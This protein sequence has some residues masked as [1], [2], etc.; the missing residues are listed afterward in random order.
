VTTAS[1]IYDGTVGH[2]RVDPVEHA[3][4]YRQAML[5]LDL[6][7]APAL[8]ERA[9]LWSMRRRAPG[10]FRRSDY[11][12]DPTVPLA[13]EV[14]AR[15]ERETGT[16]PAGPVRLLGHARTLGHCFNP[17]VFYFCFDSAGAR[18]DAVV[19][20]VNN[21]PWG[22]RHAYVLRAAPNGGSVLGER[23]DKAFH[24]SPFMG[25]DHVYD[26]RV[27]E[28]GERLSVHIA[29]TRAGELAFEA[30]LK[31]ERRELTPHALDGLLLRHPATT[32]RIV[33]LIYANA[34]KLKLKG[35]PY[36]RHPNRERSAR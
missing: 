34:L 28:P 1:A 2:R 32:L 10:Q 31:L 19:A 6:D 11:L 14:R 27:T 18:V 4:T 23:F 26:I 20:D 15:V 22:E 21:T 33:A 13:D 9:C 24:V 16:R 17:V 36:F 3:F 25:M 30:T 29:S 5:Y 7:E 12:G 35:A 8:F